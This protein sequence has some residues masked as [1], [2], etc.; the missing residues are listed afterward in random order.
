MS[1]FEFVVYLVLE[2]RFEENT[3]QYNIPKNYLY[4][5]IFIINNKRFFFFFSIL[6]H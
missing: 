4:S 3:L 6:S 1:D 2:D 5:I